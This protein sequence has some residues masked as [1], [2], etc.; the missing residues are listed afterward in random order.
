M[1]TKIQKIEMK[2]TYK[3]KYSIETE[4]G[5]FSGTCSSIDA[6]NEE[7]ALLAN[8]TKILKKNIIPLVT[9]R[10][11]YTKDKVYTWNRITNHGKANGVSTSFE[12]AQK[13]INLFK[14][15]EVIKS[16]I[17][18]SFNIIK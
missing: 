17:I 3:Y 6:V 4:L 5:L 9:A 16:N 7:I 14:T 10:Q 18:E 1:K 8:N 12:E 11:W 15:K 13:V 2:T